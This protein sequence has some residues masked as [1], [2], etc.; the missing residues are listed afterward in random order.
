[1]SEIKSEFHCIIC[2][3]KLLLL[4]YS[5]KQK[6]I[7][8]LELNDGCTG[9]RAN[10]PDSMQDPEEHSPPPVDAPECCGRWTSR[11]CCDASR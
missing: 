7:C 8:C 10:T 1:M 3:N 11:A 6:T 2:N 5:P 4:A 9:I